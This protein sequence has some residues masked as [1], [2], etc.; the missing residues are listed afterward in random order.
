[1]NNL[2][3]NLQ[4]PDYIGHQLVQ[5]LIPYTSGNTSQWV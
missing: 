4:P 5:G 1:M 2:P 3:I